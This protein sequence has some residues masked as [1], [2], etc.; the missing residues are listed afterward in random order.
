M[1]MLSHSVFTSA[2]MVTVAFNCRIVG[3]TFFQWYNK[4]SLLFGHLDG[5]LKIQVQQ[6]LFYVALNPLAF[7]LAC[8]LPNE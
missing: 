6:L 4:V 3:K 8:L 1:F 7:Q 2:L 5:L